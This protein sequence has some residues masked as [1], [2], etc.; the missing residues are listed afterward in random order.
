MVGRD[1]G[2][3]RLKFRGTT[4]L[5][6]IALALLTVPPVAGA[7]NLG[8][9]N[10]RIDYDAVAGEI[11][12]LTIKQVGANYEFTETGIVAIAAT[13]PC[14]NVLTGYARC[15]AEGI[16]DIDAVLLDLA[17]TASYDASVA[18]PG[19]AQVTVN[20]G[21]GNDV[22]T[23]AG[24]TPA[25][26]FTDAGEDQVVG[27]E[28]GDDIRTGDDNDTVDSGAGNDHLDP[29]LGADNFDAG[30]GNDRFNDSSVADPGDVLDGGPGIGDSLDSRSRVNALNLSSDGAANDGEP[31]EG[32]NLK[33]IE[34]FDSGAGADV[35]TG[36]PGP[37]AL[38]SNDGNDVLEGG[39][40]PDY[41]TAGSGTD[42]LEGGDGADYVYGSSG[43]DRISGGPGDDEFSGEFFDD[44]AD[45]YSGGS[46]TD[47]ISEI[48]DFLGRGVT[49]DL[50]GA[51]DDGPSVPQPQIPKDNAGSDMENLTMDVAGGGGSEEFLATSDVLTGN[52]SPNEIVGGAGNDRISGLGGA[53]ALEGG[54]GDDDLNGGTGIDG[55]DGAGGSD[56]IRSRDA[57]ADEVDCGSATDT[58]LADSLDDFTVTCDSSSTGAALKTPRARLKKGKAKVRILCPAAEGIICK[59]TV[60]A[61]KGKKVLAKGT[62]PVKTGETANVTLKLTKA[63]KKS[64]SK[65]LTLKAK[66]T[67]RDASGA[68][69]TTT[70]PKLVLR[71]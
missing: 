55:L 40:G 1:T 46:G 42:Q 17:D 39:G 2:V 71:R 28:G 29:G 70:L 19:L 63:G 21:I 41:L 57:G 64:R 67:F 44:G 11:N 34:R 53:D 45:V 23:A 48:V 33:R 43:A 50:D 10:G 30:P 69:V 66:T 38:H 32:D 18:G 61:A 52:D 65:K 24:P 49:I 25:G 27:G 60:S 58:L 13:A 16:T 59:V 5:L 4:V 7:A 31:G 26:F 37:N 35:L 54:P 14:V 6:G 47:S 15:P 12:E 51:A 8:T 68:Q 62:G 56:R 9:A 20:S 22:L 3:K 36:G